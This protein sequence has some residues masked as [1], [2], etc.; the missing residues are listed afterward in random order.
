MAARKKVG[1]RL[2][3]RV[4]LRV[5]V[6]E[7]ALG[8][9]QG[10]LTHVQA[11]QVVAV[12]YNAPH[13]SD[14]LPQNLLLG[15]GVGLWF[16]NLCPVARASAG[17]L[18]VG[19]F[20]DR[21]GLRVT[22]S[23]NSSWAGGIIATAESVAN[24]GAW[25]WGNGTIEE[26][27]SGW[28]GCG[29]GGSCDSSRGLCHKMTMHFYSDVHALVRTATATIERDCSGIASWDDG[30]SAWWKPDA[31]IS[32]IH[33]VHMMHLD[34]GFTNTTRGVCDTYFDQHFPRAIET[35]NELRRRQSRATFQWHTFSWLILEF[36]DGA[37]GCATRPRT[38]AELAAV[39]Q[40]IAH[41]DITWHANALNSFVELYDATM[42]QY[43]LRLSATLNKQFGKAHGL[44]CGKQTDVPGMSIAAVPQLAEGG[45]KA[46]H[47][48]YNGA[49]KVPEGLPPVL[50][51]RHEA[52]GSEVLL[53]VEAG[54]GRSLCP[55]LC[56]STSPPAPCLRLLMPALDL[57]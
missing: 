54:Y 17:C 35:A 1:G 16:A 28:C 7:F 30:G 50:R 44:V 21:E 19:D 8:A 45:V 27:A 14:V 48:G 13:D 26:R 53:M 31:T 24:A 10:V 33:M 9:T 41:D 15:V 39:R 40:A 36:L 46:M 56:Y 6:G 55:I 34:V 12:W 32:E 52:T 43:S 18:P 51:W 42:L 3:L 11:H 38:P 37:A 23:A 4:F 57:L 22:L 29:A 49:C 5:L 25:K 47:M 20:T 2:A